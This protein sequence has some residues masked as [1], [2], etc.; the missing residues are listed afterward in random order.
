MKIVIQIVLAIVIIVLAY[1]IYKGIEKPIIFEK[2]K[3]V[4]YKAV[5]QKLKDIRKAQLAFKDLKGEFAA[6]FD[7]LISC[8]K[9]DSMPIVLAIGNVPDTLSE[10]QAVE[11]GLVTRDTTRIALVDTIF[12]PGYNIDSLGYIPFTNEQFVMGNGEIVTASKVKV[13][14]FEASALYSVFLKGLDRQ[15]IINLNDEKRKNK[16]FPGLKVGSL[17]ETTNNAGNW[18]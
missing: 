13:K 17:T 8:L 5:V 10:K 7:T 3:E 15:L 2:K 6:N 18:E 14:V 12:K 4:R 11:L 1:F 16:L 9:T